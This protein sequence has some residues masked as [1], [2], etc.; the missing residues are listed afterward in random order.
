MLIANRYEIVYPL[1]RGKFGQVFKCKD[2][3]RN[4]LDVA[5]KISNDQSF[6]IDND[7]VEAKIM[8]K[9]QI[10]DNANNDEC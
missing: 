4:K 10:P 6:D 5:V 2:N 1:D 9:L 8:E 7:K 3:A